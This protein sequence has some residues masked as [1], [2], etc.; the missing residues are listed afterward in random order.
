[1]NWIRSPRTLQLG[2]A[3]LLPMLALPALAALGG[4]AT[5]V[6][7]D[8]VQLKAALRSTQK[9]NY[10]VHELAA[11]GATVREYVTPAGKVFAVGWNGTVMPDLQ[12]ILGTYYSHFAT[13]AKN[14]RARGVRGPVSVNEPGV[15]I[16]SGGHMA[17]FRGKA[18][19]PEMLPE[20][21]HPDAIQ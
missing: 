13:A 21:V 6:E 20:G 19:I 5:S 11:P 16:Q 4:D 10:A 15:V 9:T 12:Q 18:Y 14:Q 8:V 1:M 7:K 3:L 17:A 2:L